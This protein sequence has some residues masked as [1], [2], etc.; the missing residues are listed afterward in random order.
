MPMSR[1]VPALSMGCAWLNGLP[2]FCCR[3]PMLAFGSPGHR[4]A[5]CAHIE[6]ATSS[7]SCCSHSA[8]QVVVVLPTPALSWPRRHHAAYAR[9]PLAT[10]SLWCLCPSSAG[11]IVVML[12]MPTFRWPRHRRA[13]YARVQLATSPSCCLPSHSATN[14][15]TL[16]ARVWSHLSS[17]GHVWSAARVLGVLCRNGGVWARWEGGGGLVWEW[18]RWRVV[19]SQSAVVWKR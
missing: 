10:S 6:L 9:V 19:R 4:R 8:G 5:A 11:H 18:W 3:A 17:W 1:W 16:P 2:A 15:V 13:A 14:V 7:S 12:P